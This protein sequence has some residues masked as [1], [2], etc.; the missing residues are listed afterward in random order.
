MTI[1][2]EQSTR[3]DVEAVNLR[4][5]FTTWPLVSILC[6]K[7]RGASHQWSASLWVALKLHENG[8]KESEDQL[9]EIR[10]DLSAGRA[11][12]GEVGRYLFI[13]HITNRTTCE[14]YLRVS[15]LIASLRVSVC[16]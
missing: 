8:E 16:I 1:R 3:L 7:Y 11:P 14:L 5:K 4:S 13:F 12:E 9:I 10:L 6:S 2:E 15:S